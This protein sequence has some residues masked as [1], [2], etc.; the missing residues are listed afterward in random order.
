[1]YIKCNQKSVKNNEN[2]HELHTKESKWVDQSTFHID[3][4]SDVE[5]RYK[6]TTWKKGNKVKSNCTE[7]ARIVLHH[8][9]VAAT[10]ASYKQRANNRCLIKNLIHLISETK[11][12]TATKLV[13][14]DYSRCCCRCCCKISMMPSFKVISSRNESNSNEQNKQRSDAHGSNDIECA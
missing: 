14:V 10:D 9:A 12:T 4:Q 7:D 11:T 8:V 5:S 6:L 1:M 13:G 3:S 2:H